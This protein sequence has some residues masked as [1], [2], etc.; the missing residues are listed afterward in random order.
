[1]IRETIPLWGAPYCGGRRANLVHDLSNEKPNCSINVIVHCSDA[2][3]FLCLETAHREG[4]KN[5]PCC[6]D[7]A[8]PQAEDINEFLGQ[9][10]E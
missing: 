1:M 3:P 6:L 7:T 10:V 8:Q 4:Y 9:G 5:C 2:V